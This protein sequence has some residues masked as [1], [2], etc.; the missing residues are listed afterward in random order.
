MAAFHRRGLTLS[1]DG[2]YA[3][4]P[5]PVVTGSFAVDDIQ[6]FLFTVVVNMA[7]Q[8]HHQLRSASDG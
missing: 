3:Y 5:P 4:A 8:L 2:V 7:G 1:N 6:V